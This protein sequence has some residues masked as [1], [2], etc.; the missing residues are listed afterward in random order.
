MKKYS[1]ELFFDSTMEATLKGESEKLR[2]AGL[3]APLLRWGTRPHISLLLGS[4]LRDGAEQAVA[5]FARETHALPVTL[6][7]IATFP[8][9]SVVMLLPV[10]TCEL[11]ELHARAHQRLGAYFGESD[12]H[13]A[14]ARW[15]P[16]CTQ[17]I[18]LDEDELQATLRHFR[19][20]PLPISGRLASVGIHITTIDLERQGAER[21]VGSEYPFEAAFSG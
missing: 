1:V 20:T 19:A 2:D 17:S 13:Y 8:H 12:P 14:P 10:V 6:D 18:F 7:V 5:A 4:E 15:I 16:H 11:L 21:F 3:P 9:R